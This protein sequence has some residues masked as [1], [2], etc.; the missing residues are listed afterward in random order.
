MSNNPGELAKV[1][2]KLE[3]I[4]QAFN[5]GNGGKKVSLANL[6]VLGGSAAVEKTAKAAGVNVKV[7]FRTHGRVAGADRRR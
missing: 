7:P 5:A 4:Q 2:K 1:L 3:A 6:I